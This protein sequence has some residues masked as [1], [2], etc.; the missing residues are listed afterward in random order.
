MDTKARADL[1]RACR[2]ETKQ[3]RQRQADGFAALDAAGRVQG[4]VDR[5]VRRVQRAANRA[6]ARV[7]R[8]VEAGLDRLDFVPGSTAEREKLRRHAR[9]QVSRDQLTGFRYDARS[10]PEGIRPEFRR[11]SQAAANRARST[12]LR[13]NAGTGVNRHR[14]ALRDIANNPGRV[15]EAERTAAIL[16]DRAERANR[17]RRRTIRGRVV[18][19]DRRGPVTRTTRTD[20]G[21]D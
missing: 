3:S 20:R 10:N 11:R 19:H 4:R 6:G 15:T 5:V 18:Y 14:G 1:V 12:E 13:A 7:G 21:G 16:R 8:S 2:E 9:R 17:P